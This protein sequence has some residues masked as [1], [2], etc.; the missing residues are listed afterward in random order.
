MPCL[1]NH[2]TFV[3]NSDILGISNV[4]LAAH[5][6]N[7][8]LTSLNTRQKVY[9]GLCNRG[10]IMV[11]HVE[12]RIYGFFDSFSTILCCV[13]HTALEMAEVVWMATRLLFGQFGRSEYVSFAQTKSR[14]NR[15][16]FGHYF[17]LCCITPTKLFVLYLS[18]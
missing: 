13:F 5:N 1:G 10:E 8:M 4:V 14:N 11:G 9:L 6:L 2:L 16:M 15:P 17:H 7:D 12:S 18:Q 3:W